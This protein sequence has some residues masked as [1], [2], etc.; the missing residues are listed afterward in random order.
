MFVLKVN[1][2]SS[3][4]GNSGFCSFFGLLST[5]ENFSSVRVTFITLRNREAIEHK[6]VLM[7]SVVVLEINLFKG[8]R[9][10]IDCIVTLPRLGLRQTGLWILV[11]DH[12][13]HKE[14]ICK[15][16]SKRTHSSVNTCSLQVHSNTQTETMSGGC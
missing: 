2:Q 10:G 12:S 6:A 5:G 7:N 3:S 16:V 14:F 11:Q 15:T 4:S 1:N 9:L 13:S 8:L